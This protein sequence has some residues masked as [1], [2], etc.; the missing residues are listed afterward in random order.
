MVGSIVV[1][2]FIQLKN[3]PFAV[4]EEG[5]HEFSLQDFKEMFVYNDVRVKQY[6]GLIAAIINLKEA[7]CPAIYLD[8]S[9]V[10]QKPVPG[11]YDACVDYTGVD[12]GI[13]DPVFTTFDNQRQAQKEKYEG[14]FFPHHIEADR[15]GTIF[16]DF[17]QKEKHSGGR[18]GIIKL[19]LT[20]I[21]LVE[22]GGAQ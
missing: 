9:Y 6:I 2:K 21:D 16:I 14:E 4:L 8:G 1:S 13:L 10:T 7:G 15:I 18:K 19:D 12:F 11:D 22:L 20:N 5:I 17:F 3:A